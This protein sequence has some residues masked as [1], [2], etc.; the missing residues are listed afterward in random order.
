MTEATSGDEAEG[1]WSTDKWTFDRQYLEFHRLTYMRQL[2]TV[3][4]HGVMSYLQWHS[5]A[6]ECTSQNGRIRKSGRSCKSTFGR[7]RILAESQKFTTFGAETVTETDIRS[8]SRR[9]K[10]MYWHMTLTLSN[11]S[12]N[13]S[14]ETVNV[15]PQRCHV[16][17]PADESSYHSY[18]QPVL[19][20]THHVSARNIHNI[21]TG[22]NTPQSFP[23]KTLINY[24]FIFRTYVSSAF[25]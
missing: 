24:H 10:T 12:G 18:Q 4:D 8:T 25:M 21:V 15:S 1:G 14:T 9:N 13:G 7:N 19:Q 6:A 16:E 2:P 23:C 5:A 11:S 17:D 22:I 20:H 3:S